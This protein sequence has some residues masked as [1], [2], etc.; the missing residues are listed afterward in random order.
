MSKT[1]ELDSTYYFYGPARYWGAYY[2]AL[3]SFAGQD[4]E[5]SADYFAASLSAAPNYF[6]TRVLRAEYLTVLTGDVAT[7][8][9]DLDFVINGD[10]TVEPAVAAENA[11][12]QEK[13]TALLARMHELFDKKTLEAAAAA[14]PAA[15]AEEA[16]AEEAPAEEAA[17][18]TEAPA[19]AAEAATAEEAPAKAAEAATTTEAPAKAAEAA[20]ATEAAG[21]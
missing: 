4:L 10:P 3:P 2:S 16:P 8:T 1:A 11:K 5:K 13:A 18:A 7:F 6:G 20:T 9:S 19:K 12:E 17:P 15:P 21:E 14:K